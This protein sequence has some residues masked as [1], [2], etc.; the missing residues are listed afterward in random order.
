MAK[1][2]I[3]YREGL[4]LLGAVAAEIPLE[5]S[6]ARLDIAPWRFFTVQRPESRP[7]E[8][9][10]SSSERKRALLEI[11]SQDRY[12]LCGLTTGF[13]ESPYSPGECLRRLGVAAEPAT[14]PS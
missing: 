14:S 10:L 1:L 9:V 6:I 3:V 2:W 4:R 13:F 12:D 11:E 5:P 8:D 7:L